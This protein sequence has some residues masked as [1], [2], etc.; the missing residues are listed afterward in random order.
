VQLREQDILFVPPYKTRVEIEGEVKRKG[1]FEIKNDE[2]ISDLIRFAGGFGDKAYS[3]SLTVL[4][5]NNKEREVRN[6][7]ASDFTKFTMQNGDFVRTDSILN[8]FSNRVAINGAVFHPGNFELT[9]GMKLSDLIKKADGLRE[10]AFMNRGMISRI[11]E[12]NSPENISF[13]IKEVMQGRNDIVLRKEDKVSIRS[14]FELREART[15]SIEGEVIKP[16][17]FE[18]EENMTLG[19]LVFKSGGFHEEADLSVVEVTRRLSYEQAAKVTDKMNEIFQFALT[20]DL[21]LSPED[22]AFK[23][24]PFDLVF[25]RR[26]PGY[27]DQGTFYITGEVTYAGTYTISDKNERLSDAIKRAG[28]LI[29]GAF[30]TGATLTRKSKQS[31]AEIEKKK[32]LMRMDTTLMDTILTEYRSYPVGIALDK[33]LES[34]GSSIDL[35]LQPGDVIYVPRELQT[36]KV[37]GS[38]MNPLALT[39]AKRLTVKRYINMA[40]GYDDFARKSRTY[41]IYPNGTT[42]TTKGFIFRRSPGI[43]PGAEIIVPKKIEKKHTDNTL[44]WISIASGLSSLLIAVITLVN[45]SK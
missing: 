29:P 28:G 21:K 17:T 39:Y 20:R 15:V 34:P 14:I 33:I 13:D 35:M 1:I 37:S 23:L 30:T 36:I 32:Q 27:R 16:Q 2:T 26:A 10:D 4:R 24:Q 25:V 45:L 22:A 31:A 43:T 11:K 5:N 12:D 9:P 8:R 18:Y 38:V 7:I 41:V 6:V 42:E 3:Q 44:K 19:D 40:G